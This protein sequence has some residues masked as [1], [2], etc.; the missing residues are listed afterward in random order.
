[1]GLF[2]KK[3]GSTEGTTTREQVC[4]TLQATGQRVAGERG[5]RIANRV[6]E[7]IGCGRITF[8]EDP[9]CLDCAPAE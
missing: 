8:C 6:S 1:M 4:R 7:A 2:S 5:G 3:T 9:A